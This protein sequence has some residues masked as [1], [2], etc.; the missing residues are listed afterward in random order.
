M[1]RTVCRV[2]TWLSAFIYIIYLS[3]LYWRLPKFSKH[4]APQ[5][6]GARDGTTLQAKLAKRRRSAG[7]SVSLASVAVAHATNSAR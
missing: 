5:A 3:L 4:R 7:A 1:T 2:Q 6:R